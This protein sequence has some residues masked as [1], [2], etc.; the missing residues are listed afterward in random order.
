MSKRR[1]RVSKERRTD[2]ARGAGGTSVASSGTESGRGAAARRGADDDAALK[3]SP[4]ARWFRRPLW[5]VIG[6]AAIVR[7]E[8]L[9]LF[10]T[11]PLYEFHVADHLYYREWAL[12][13]AGGDWLG[14]EVF[15]QGPLYPYLLGAVFRLFGPHDFVPL[16]LQA[17][18]GV[19]TCGLTYACGERLFGRTTAIVAGALA[20]VCGPL[21]FYDVMLMKSFLSPL[22]TMAALYALLRAREGSAFR[23]APLAG[24][25]IGLACL[26]RENHLLLLMPALAWLA[27]SRPSRGAGADLPNPPRIRAA[28]CAVFLAGWA[29]AVSPATIRNAAVAREFV[30]ATAGGGEVLYMAHAP[31]ANGFYRPPGWV[32]ALPGQEHEDFRI[33]ARRRTGREMTRT[34]SSRYWSGEARRAV[35]ADP[36]RALK[37]VALKGAILFHDFEVPDSENYRAYVWFVPLLRVLPTFGWIVGLGWIGLALACRDLRGNLLPIGFAAVHVASVLVTYNFGRFRLGMMPLWILFAA[38]A[39]VWIAGAWRTRRRAAIAAGVAAVALSAAAFLPP[40]G[41]AEMTYDWDTLRLVGNLG[42]RGDRP[43]IAEAGYREAIAA[44]RDRLRRLSVP[45]PETTEGIARYRAIVM[46]QAGAE[47]GTRLMESAA[48]VH[49]RLGVALRMREDSAGWIA[50]PSEE[51]PAEHFRLALEYDRRN[52]MALFQSADIAAEQGRFPEAE[53][54]YRKLLEVDVRHEE[55]HRGLAVAL[56]ADGRIAEAEKHFRRAIEIE[57]NYVEARVDLARELARQNRTAEAIEQLREA[58][59]TAPDYEPAGDLLLRLTP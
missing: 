51:T 37:L 55:G 25:A 6:L 58:Q 29:L 50:D 16:M 26:V 11:S 7:L 1:R 43:D 31:E 17:I 54:F 28:L 53:G 14:A 34:E 23:W 33:E 3:R 41:Y 8:Y 39:A 19:G 49:A 42:L 35:L 45:V 20:A 36:G 5:W 56:A 44:H 12:R 22:L 27:L 4:L 52:A 32:S 10:A 2:R 57:P 13:I 30:L 48:D 18:A 38:H 59:R 21:V 47:K 40:P 46:R 15:E 9:V 24:A